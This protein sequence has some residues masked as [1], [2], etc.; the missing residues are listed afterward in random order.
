M[1]S[2]KR[3]LALKKRWSM[4]PE[5]VRKRMAS[6]AASARWLKATVEEKREHS[7]KMNKAKYNL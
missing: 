4:I 3:S 5:D 1:K 6:R 2:L 7:L